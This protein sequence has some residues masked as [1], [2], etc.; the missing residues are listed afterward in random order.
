MKKLSR[1]SLPVIFVGL[2]W[3]TLT[4]VQAVNVT[5]TATNERSPLYLPME[6]PEIDDDSL[7][8]TFVGKNGQ[9]IVTT[10]DG[11][12][13]KGLQDFVKKQ[14]DPIASVVVVEV[15]TGRILA[16]V[17]GRNPKSWGST[18]HTGLYPGFPAASIFKVVPTAAALEVVHM[19]PTIQMGGMDRCSTVNPRGLWLYNFSPG[20][21]GMSLEHAF[22]HSCNSFFAKLAVQYVG[23][24]LMEQFA[25]K[26]GWGHI[27]PADFYIP[28][29]PLD[30]PIAGESN[31]QTVGRFAAGFGR[32]GLSPVHAAWV[33]LLIANKGRAQPLRITKNEDAT[34]TSETRNESIID[35]ATSW[36]IRQIMHKTVVSGTAHHAFRKHKYRNILAHVGG[37][38]GSLTSQELNAKVTWF[39]GLMPYE[40][41]EV[42]VSSVVVLDPKGWNIR[43]A[44]LAAEALY[45]WS[46]L[47][48]E[49]EKLR[50]QT[51]SQQKNKDL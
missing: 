44:D 23:M 31:I 47:K 25:D 3:P 43:G 36:K 28:T 6:L 21:N 15:K 38:T 16:L 12:L 40:D 10:L 13:Q 33:N 5:K 24:G 11:K 42:I 1:Y 4:H 35:E 2:L 14:N 46:Q 17:Q 9:S 49:R 22:A 50:M 18:V 41:P 26:F 51:L 34:Y 32:V 39:A 20:E 8:V 27:I 29:S 37:K 48:I 45:Q 30:L 19:D 7:E